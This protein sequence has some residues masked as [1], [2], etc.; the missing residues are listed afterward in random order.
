VS[1][2]RDLPSSRAVAAKMVPVNK[3]LPVAA[4]IDPLDE[5]DRVAV[6]ARLHDLFS[7]GELRLERLSELLETVLAAPGHADLEAAMLALPLLVRLTPASRRLTKP[8]VLRTPDGSLQLGSGR[9]DRYRY[10]AACGVQA[11]VKGPGDCRN[12]P[13]WSA[14]FEVQGSIYTGGGRRTT[15]KD[16]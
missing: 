15:L 6:I 11:R 14:T 7:R 12:D 9:V 8:L 3:D 16:C 4:A 10:W 13:S 5:G 2:Q 1:P